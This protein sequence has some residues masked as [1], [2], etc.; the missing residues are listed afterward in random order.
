M[1]HLA[2]VDSPAKPPNVY[3]YPIRTS[4]ALNSHSNG[5]AEQ[6]IRFADVTVDVGRRK[7]TRSGEMVD[8]TPAEYNLLLFFVQ[9]V[10]R[11][12]TR[13]V[14]L[15]A[16]WGCENGDWIVFI[17]GNDAGRSLFDPRSSIWRS[18]SAQNRQTIVTG[19]NLRS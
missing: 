10:D 17:V 7:I 4:V 18:E 5:I 11:P 2:L 15:N 13:D 1:N 19:R 3:A 8:V 9:N 16:A 6:I 12:L 14:I